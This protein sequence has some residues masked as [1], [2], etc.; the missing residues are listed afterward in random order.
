M[1]PK[2]K[3]DKKALDESISHNNQIAEHNKKV[4]LIMIAG[5]IVAALVSIF[6]AVFIT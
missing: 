1:S 4:I 3:Q 2:L 6:I 5:I